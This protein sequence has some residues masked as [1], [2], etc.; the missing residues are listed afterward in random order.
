M[1]V[2]VLVQLLHIKSEM[3]EVYFSYSKQTTE[4]FFYKE[5]YVLIDD[6]SLLRYSLIQDFKQ[7]EEDVVKGVL[8]KINKEA[9][10]KI[11]NVHSVENRR[12][13]ICLYYCVPIVAIVCI[14]I[15]VYV[16]LYRYRKEKQDNVYLLS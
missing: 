10:V 14:C 13:L 1:L 9:V 3:I 2:N 4:F 5:M 15:I 11:I 12:F 7:K 6:P 16:L 8:E